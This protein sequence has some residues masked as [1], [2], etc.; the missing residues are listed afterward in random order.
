M[1]HAAVERGERTTDAR[2]MP[3]QCSRTRHSTLPM[4]PS[5][6]QACCVLQLCLRSTSAY[7]THAAVN[8]NYYIQL[9]LDSNLNSSV[10]YCCWREQ[11]ASTGK[12][13]CLVKQD[14]VHCSI[15][16]NFRDQSP[17]ISSTQSMQCTAVSKKKVTLCASRHPA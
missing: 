12:R 17:L 10:P 16:L 15:Q 14:G 6:A 2:A 8:S 13:T 1:T 4:H 11:K 5:Y 7:G 3:V 9:V